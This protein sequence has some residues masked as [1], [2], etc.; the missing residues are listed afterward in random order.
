M[1]YRVF[2]LPQKHSYSSR[3]SPALSL[4]EVK[5]MLEKPSWSVKSL[6][7]T[8]R[9]VKPDEAITQKKLHHLL[10]L[11]ALP[12][13]TSPE[14]E[15]RMIQTLESSLHFVRA[16]HDVNTTGVK[17]LQGIRDETEAAEKENEI[18]LESMKAELHK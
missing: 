5:I 12:L 9:Q 7:D 8:E 4:D 10:R 6:L 14:E 1:Q 16:I 2:N 18:N 13:P 3:V 15:A 11:S 17:P